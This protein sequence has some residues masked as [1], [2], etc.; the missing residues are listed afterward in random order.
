MFKLQIINNGSEPL[1]NPSFAMAFKKKQFSRECEW[2]VNPTEK[3][4]SSNWN[5]RVIYYMEHNHM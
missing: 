3:G 1:A 4:F 5:P 2:Y